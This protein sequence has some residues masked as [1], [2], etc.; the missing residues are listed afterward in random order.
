MSDNVREVGAAEI[1]YVRD[2][3]HRHEGHHRIAVAGR[4]VVVKGDGATKSRSR[5][6]AA[7]RALS[8]VS[9]RGGSDQDAVEQLIGALV[10]IGATNV[11]IDNQPILPDAPDRILAS[12]TLDI[13]QQ[14]SSIDV[15]VGSLGGDS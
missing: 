15:V 1:T 4:T 7:T 10:L 14:G 11:T 8:A 13:V 3:G 12:L 6:G 5:S 9:E 2:P